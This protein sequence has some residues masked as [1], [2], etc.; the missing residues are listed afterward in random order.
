MGKTRKFDSSSFKPKKKFD[1]KL[2]TK[3]KNKLKNLRSYD[4]LS[5]DVLE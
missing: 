3:V 4:I 2:R 5:E 1:R